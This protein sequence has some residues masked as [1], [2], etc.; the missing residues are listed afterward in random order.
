MVTLGKKY[1]FAAIA[2]DVVIFTMQNNLLKVL[3]IN[4][5]KPPFTDFWACPGGLVKP[6]E[7][8]E[9]SAKSHLL[10]K[11]GVKGIYLEQLHTFGRVDRDPFGRVVSVA[12]FALASS[13]N[14]N[15]STTKEY[16]DVA[17]FP[18]KKL[19][20]L[21]Y[22]HLEVISKAVERLKQ[23]LEHSNIV[24]TLLPKH[25]SLGD[26]QNIYE[27]ILDRNLDKRNFRKKVLSLN[28][29][30]ETKGKRVGQANRPARLYE[31]VNKNPQEIEVL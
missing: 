26:L 24:Y 9:E 23:K 10:E 8:V 28:M 5:K 1:Q 16:K 15:L 11:T 30:R 25:F 13:D 2:T 18:V 27:L 19:P 14:I 29:V 3:L 17:W 31:F 20:K 22:D 7:S 6:D 12:Y 4:M 21:A